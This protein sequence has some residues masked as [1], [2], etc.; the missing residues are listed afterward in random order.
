M[1]KTNIFYQYFII[2]YSKGWVPMETSFSKKSKVNSELLQI[3]KDIDK[4]KFA[5]ETA[6]SNFDNVTEPDLIDCYIYEVNSSLKRY[7]YLLEQAAKL[8]SPPEETQ[9]KKLLNVIAMP[10]IRD[11]NLDL[12]CSLLTGLFRK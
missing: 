9:D 3:M 4:T 12:P 7:K 6:Y 5:L 1:Y 11:L 2:R 8:S 10:K